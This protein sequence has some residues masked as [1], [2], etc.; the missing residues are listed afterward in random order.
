MLQG[1]GDGFCGQ[2]ALRQTNSGTDGGKEASYCYRLAYAYKLGDKP[3]QG[4]AFVYVNQKGTV[5]V[6]FID[7]FLRGAARY[8]YRAG[9]LKGDGSGNALAVFERH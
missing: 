9:N 5:G 2:L 4:F 7:A 1:N 6:V 3:P 8:R